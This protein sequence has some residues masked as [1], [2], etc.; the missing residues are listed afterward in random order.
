MKFKIECSYCGKDDLKLTEREDIF[1]CNNC[2]TE[3]TF[4]KLDIEIVED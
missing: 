3:L 1:Y 4:S 2:E